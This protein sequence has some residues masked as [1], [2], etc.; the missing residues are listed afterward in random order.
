MKIHSW[1]VILIQVGQETLIIDTCHLTSGYV[2][3]LSNSVISWSWKQATVTTETQ[4]V[5]LSLVA[6]EA[7]WLR[8]VMYYYFRR[9]PRSHGASQESQISQPN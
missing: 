9:Q 4:Y 2:F 7:I 1:L 5:A 6:Q 3:Q 8:R